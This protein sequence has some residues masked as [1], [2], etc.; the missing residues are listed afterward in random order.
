M[1][2][3]TQGQWGWEVYGGWEKRV[4]ETGYPRGRELG[5]ILQH[6][7]SFCNRK[8]TKEGTTKEDGGNLK[9]KVPARYLPSTPPPARLQLLQA[10]HHMM[11]IKC[12]DFAHF[13]L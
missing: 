5:E 8:K 11:H 2:M 1:G 3:G 13:D 4:Q 10:F 12:C 7:T 9:Y 6:C